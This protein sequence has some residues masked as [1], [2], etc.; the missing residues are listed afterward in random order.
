MKVGWLTDPAGYTGGAELTMNEFHAAAPDTVE[1]IDC[2]P[3]GIVPGLDTYVIGN[4]VRYTPQELEPILTTAPA[5]K[6]WHDVGP[7]VPIE[8][9]ELLDAHA[10]P[11]CCSPVQA[12][13]M[14]L[15]AVLIPPPID[16]DRFEQAAASVNGDRKGAVS[17]GQWRNFG[18]A[19]HRV[20]EWSHRTQT[21]VDFYG[22]GTFAPDGSREIDYRDM[23]ALL[24]RY[25]TFVFLPGVLEPFGRTVAEA[26]A[27]GCEI[28]ANRLVGA[29]HW[30]ENDPD[31]IVSAGEDFWRLVVGAQAVV[32]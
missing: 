18:K 16:L 4:C 24:A 23:P 1:I 12:E 17:V 14:G 11:V 31:A 25:E 32:A 29:L 3:C 20:V 8:V 6:Y 26:W 27:S 2:P 19:A 9:R 21:P 10:I 22:G 7:W 15:A 13:Q 30:I 5:V 28:V